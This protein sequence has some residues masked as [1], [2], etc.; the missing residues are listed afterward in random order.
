MCVMLINCKGAGRGSLTL[1]SLRNGIVSI[2]QFGV[3]G[4]FSCDGFVDGW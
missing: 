3:C 4:D 2:V 1:S